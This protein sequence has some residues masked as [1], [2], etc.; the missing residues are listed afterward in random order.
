MASLGLTERG[1]VV[2]GHTFHTH[3]LTKTGEHRKNKGF[4]CMYD[5]ALGCTHS[6]PGL[7]AA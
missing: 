7:Q 6:Y 2:L 3:T 1:R 4:K 5:F